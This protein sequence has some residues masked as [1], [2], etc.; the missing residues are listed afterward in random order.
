MGHLVWGL[1]AKPALERAVEKG[2]A[3]L[4]KRST[5]PE[6]DTNDKRNAAARK[7]VADT[8]ENF[9]KG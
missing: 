8:I 4:A 7:L 5:P 6:P 9:G 2:K 3:K 1:M